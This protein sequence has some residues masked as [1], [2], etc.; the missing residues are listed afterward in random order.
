MYAVSFPRKTLNIP[1]TFLS[2][3]ISDLVISL[4]SCRLSLDFQSSL[5]LNK[6]YWYLQF[7]FLFFFLY[8]SDLIAVSGLE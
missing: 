3:H 7:S 8:L 6:N 4:Q 1:V 2:S 5:N